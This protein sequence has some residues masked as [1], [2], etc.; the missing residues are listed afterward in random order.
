M[1]S[2]GQEIFLGLLA[3]W[4]GKPGG[5]WQ[6]TSCTCTPQDGA[7]H[8]P[9]RSK[10]P[11]GARPS[12]LPTTGAKIGCWEGPIPTGKNVIGGDYHGAA[13]HAPTYPAHH[14]DVGPGF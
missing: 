12:P 11:Q 6:Q 14:P 5:L 2:V 7:A 1:Q 3:P 13:L 4:G 8:L 10:L 9:S